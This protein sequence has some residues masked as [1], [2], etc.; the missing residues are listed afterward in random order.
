MNNK[1]SLNGI[2]LIYGFYKYLWFF[3]IFP[4]PIQL[5][6][7]VIIS[8]I[9]IYDSKGKLRLNKW[10]NYLLILA[11]I[12]FT[13]IM[14]DILRFPDDVNRLFAAINTATLWLT[15]GIIIGYVIHCKAKLDIIRIGRYCVINIYINAV[16]ALLAAFLYYVMD[17]PSVVFLGKNLY[18]TNWLNSRA[19]IKYS[20]FNDYPNM[21]LFF[22]M[23]LFTMSIP[24]LKRKGRIFTFWVVSICCL[25]ELIIHSRSGLVLFFLSFVIFLSENMLNK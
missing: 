8:V 3:I 7:L 5:I 23:L 21:N 25:S 9:M 13:A 19:V 17:I 1:R 11:C 20:G 14:C 22:L 16:M 10:A 15:S 2:N 24:Y 4:K 18:G 12:H 6:L